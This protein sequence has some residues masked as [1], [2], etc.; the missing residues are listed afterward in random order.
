M[1]PKT[2]VSTLLSVIIFTFHPFP[3]LT[4]MCARGAHKQHQGYIH[5]PE[6]KIHISYSKNHNSTLF[7]YY[8]YMSHLPSLAHIIAKGS[9]FLINSSFDGTKLQKNCL[10]VSSTGSFPYQCQWTLIF[11]S[12]T[13]PMAMG[14]QLGFQRHRESLY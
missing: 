5:I 7:F 13:T 1:F 2:T 8:F 6:S 10:D 11:K 3:H 12:L 9:I 4:F 14:T